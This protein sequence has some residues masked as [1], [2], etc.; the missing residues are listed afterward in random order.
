MGSRGPV[1]KRSDQRRRANKPAGPPPKSGRGSSRNDWA[2]YALSIGV[3]VPEGAS[4]S[5]IFAAVAEQ[6]DPDWHPLARQLFDSLSKSGQAV[7]Y[8][9]SDW[10]MAR[11]VAES[12]SRELSPQPMVVRLGEEAFIEWVAL[13]PKGA[14]LAAWLKA[15]SVLGMTEGDR[16]RMGIELERVA[17][18]DGQEA[19]NDV[20]DLNEYRRRA[21]ARTS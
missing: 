5:E 1:P 11:V 18:D 9:P 16:R 12:I 20:S 7:F 6:H 10:A 21:E 8:Q 2:A 13:P 3:V 14:S 15:S 19:V 17:A 4:R